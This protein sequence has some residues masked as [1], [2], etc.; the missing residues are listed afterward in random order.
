[1]HWKA[2][3]YKIFLSYVGIPILRGVL[4]RRYD[5]QF[6]CLALAIFLLLRDAIEPTD[7]VL[8]ETLLLQFVSDFE[9]LYT[10]RFMMMNVHLADY[11][12]KTGVDLC[13]QTVASLHQGLTVNNWA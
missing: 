13:L 7:L 2:S 12:R 6:S 11:V 3:E 4:S 9:E 1:M 10:L 5:I 8:A